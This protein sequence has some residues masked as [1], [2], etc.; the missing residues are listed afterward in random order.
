MSE[1]I[2][3]RLIEVALPIQ[4]IRAEMLYR[5]VQS[6]VEESDWASQGEAVVPESEA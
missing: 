2:C 5:Q 3:P 4:G 6:L 1:D